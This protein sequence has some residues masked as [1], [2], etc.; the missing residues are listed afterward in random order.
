[1][2][3]IVIAEI[4]QKL[5]KIQREREQSVRDILQASKLVLR[6]EANYVAA[7]K[8][9]NQLN[10]AYRARLPELHFEQYNLEFQLEA[11]RV[12]GVDPVLPVAV[13]Q[14]AP[15]LTPAA[16][17]PPELV[18]ESSSTTY[19]QKRDA[20]GAML[21]D[22]IEKPDN[23]PIDI[24]AVFGDVLKAAPVLPEANVN[25]DISDLR[26]VFSE[27]ALIVPP[28][29]YAAPT[30]TE[31]QRLALESASL[32]S[33]APEEIKRCAPV[34]LDGADSTVV[35]LHRPSRVPA[36]LTQPK[37]DPA[38]VASA[39][40]VPVPVTMPYASASEVGAANV[41]AV[42]A[43]P[44]VE[45]ESVYFSDERDTYNIAKPWDFIRYCKAYPKLVEMFTVRALTWPNTRG[46]KL[47]I[48]FFYRYNVQKDIGFNT[49]NYVKACLAHAYHC[50]HP[51]HRNVFEIAHNVRS[52]GLRTGAVVA[53]LWKLE[54][55]PI[56]K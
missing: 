17:L 20:V 3:A 4:K 38:P 7:L 44:I 32:Q 22:I 24:R 23:E 1:M 12:D 29:N 50:Q 47:S 56:Y 5:Q 54:G 33:T 19:A 41:K 6:L 15:V 37:S 43:A 2:N 11:E 27:H 16:A 14:P 52:A 30:L 34:A 10:T 53:A 48:A 31:E 51:G 55:M 25:S 35:V 40:P 45:T 21:M 46:G 18:L 13:A 36:E 8:A 9:H 49:S 39:V 28:T 42:L 26:A